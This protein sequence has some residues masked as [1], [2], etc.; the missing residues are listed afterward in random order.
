MIV[1]GAFTYDR[2]GFEDA[3][4][5]LASG[6]LPNDALIEPGAVGLDGLLDVMRDL[7]AGRIAGKVLVQP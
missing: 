2:G 3:L 1:T 5:L 4:E 7:A 6:A